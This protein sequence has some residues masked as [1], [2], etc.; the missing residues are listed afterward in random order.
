LITFALL[1]RH[2]ALVE[3]ALLELVVKPLFLN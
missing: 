1:P 3:L 2:L